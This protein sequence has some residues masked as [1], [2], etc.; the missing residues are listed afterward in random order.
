[1]SEA[2]NDRI[3][4]VMQAPPSAPNFGRK[5]T[6][7]MEEGSPRISHAPLDAEGLVTDEFLSPIDQSDVPPWGAGVGI[8][9]TSRGTGMSYSYGYQDAGM[10]AHRGTLHP[11]EYVDET[12]VRQAAEELLGFT[13]ADITAV[14]RQGPKSSEQRQLR[15]RIDARLLALS[16]S[17]GLP[18]LAEILNLNEKTLDRALKRAKDAK[19]E[20]IVKN[21]AVKTALVCFI[22]GTPDARPRRRS[23]KGCPASM[24]P[25]PQYRDGTINLSDRAF[26]RG[27]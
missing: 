3:E 24:L 7:I 15:A 1:V 10:T 8:V 9:D 22:E 16:V 14:Y 17:G 6:H 25:L 21:P 4:D 13:Y 18:K 20:P 19:V 27:Q 12:L 2:D 23:H 11:D 26:A 5:T